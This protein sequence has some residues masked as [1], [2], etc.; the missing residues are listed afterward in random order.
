MTASVREA[1]RPDAERSQRVRELIE[2]AAD[3]TGFVPFDRF[4]EICLY[5]PGVGY[6][7]RDPT[8]LGAEG[9]F[10]TAAHATPLFGRAIAERVKAVAASLDPTASLR[11]VEVGPGDGALAES[12]LAGVAEDPRLR[13]RVEYV[14][15]ERSPE[16]AVRT[17]ERV[18]DAGRT[19]G[20]P[21]KAAGGLGA[22]G[23]FRG[24]VLANELLDAQPARRLVFDGSTWQEGGVRLAGERW[25]W[26]TSADVR[27][28]P[29]PELPVGV[30]DGTV[31]EISPMAE[32]FVR[33]VADH[34]VDGL[35][36]LLDFG[37]DQSELLAAHP[38]GTLSAV[39]RHR[40]VPDPL[41]D[42]GL[43]DLSVFVNFTRLR[44]VAAAAGLRE[45]AF[46]RQAEA[47]GAWGFEGLL[48]AALRA[49]PTAETEVR[50]RLAAKNLL[51]GFER[52][53][54]LELAPPATRGVPSVLGTR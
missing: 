39:Q 36:L 46:R 16:L 37:M 8:P 5:G 48:D 33:E 28:V 35:C 3:A 10:Y 24:I 45:V 4:I 30:S 34:L 14:L 41:T 21:V 13:E 51:F 53:H 29:S 49:S 22:D 17:F 40:F 11:I 26:A 32:A 23:P 18:R 25:A 52:F 7:T 42:P 50:T 15:I 6:Y 54:A 44:G 1:P 20:V 43:S 31:L 27:P 19:L 47:L 9:D 2:R 12:V 38:T